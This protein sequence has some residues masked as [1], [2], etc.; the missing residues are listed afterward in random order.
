MLAD[1]TLP[2]PD[3]V[4]ALIDA[5]D[6]ATMEHL[7]GPAVGCRPYGGE[8]IADVPDLLRSRSWPHRRQVFVVE[9]TGSS[10]EDDRRRPR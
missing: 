3:S 4:A 8:P 7:H 5:V 6:W 1:T 2:N 10:D 9:C